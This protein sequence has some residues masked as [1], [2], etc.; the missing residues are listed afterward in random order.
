MDKATLGALTSAK[1][2]PPKPHRRTHVRRGVS[3][4]GELADFHSFE[5]ACRVF[6]RN[7]ALLPESS[8]RS[9]HTEFESTQSLYERPTTILVF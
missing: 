4:T 7:F 5:K 2:E 9:V 3:P 1:H 6:S 8:N